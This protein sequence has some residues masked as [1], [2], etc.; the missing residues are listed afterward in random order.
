[1]YDAVE[2]QI[3][4]GTNLNIHHIISPKI[5]KKKVQL[6]RKMS[7]LA[8]LVNKLTMTYDLYLT[9]FYCSSRLEKGNLIWEKK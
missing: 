8:T 2:K 4:Y 6:M 1:M 7:N 3:A 9:Y 5:N